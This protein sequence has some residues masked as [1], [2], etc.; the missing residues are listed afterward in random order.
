MTF[1][2]AKGL[3]TCDIRDVAYEACHFRDILFY[4]YLFYFFD[5]WIVND[6]LYA[7]CFGYVIG[8]P[9]FA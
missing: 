4:V 8:Y 6:G 1:T 5:D 7:L 9:L 3:S 2:S